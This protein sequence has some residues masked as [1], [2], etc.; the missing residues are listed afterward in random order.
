MGTGLWAHAVPTARAA[1]DAPLLVVGVLGHSEDVEAVVDGVLAVGAGAAD[2][3]ACVIG[4]NVNRVVKHVRRAGHGVGRHRLQQR[5]LRGAVQGAHDVL[6]AVQSAETNFQP[7]E[8]S[9]Q[10]FM[11]NA[12]VLDAKP[13]ELAWWRDVP[14][15]ARGDLYYIH[16]LAETIKSYGQ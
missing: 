16:K 12:W 8:D 10:L 15:L 11:L 5:D 14:W 9:Y 1:G 2:E 7:P 4:G 6:P 3:P 13:A